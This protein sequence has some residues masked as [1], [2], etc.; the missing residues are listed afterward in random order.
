MIKISLIILLILI[1]FSA[2]AGE[3]ELR[4][5]IEKTYP[6]LTIKSIQKTQYNDLYEIYIGGQIIYSDE[7]F[8]FLIVEGRVV[9]PKTKVDLTTARLE[10]L[11]KVDFNSLPFKN[12]IKEVRGDGSRRIAVFSDVDCPF[13]RKL[14][15]ETITK[16]T[17][18]TIYTFLYPLAIHP[19]AKEKSKKIWCAKNKVDAWS[20]YMIKN[21]L[22][23]NDGSCNTPVEANLE[24]AR[25][26]GISSTPT[27]IMADGKRIEGA[28][29]YE[30]IA[31]F[32]K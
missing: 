30:E 14:E 8:S 19:D 28:L 1:N 26:L 17:D 16:L 6:E 5:I 29:P 22:P 31:K 15:K 9:D 13:C 32:I 24:L 23:E 27:I 21:S 12:A 2:E 25:K 10:E 18:I 3:K 11:N 7:S 20:N 4:E